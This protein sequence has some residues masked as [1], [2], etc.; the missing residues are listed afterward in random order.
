VTDILATALA[1]EGHAVA[2]M[3]ATEQIGRQHRNIF[4]PV[5]RGATMPEIDHHPQIGPVGREQ[6][7]HDGR[8]GHA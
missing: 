4:R 8:V 7:R 2:D 3:N 5:A 6:L 1:F